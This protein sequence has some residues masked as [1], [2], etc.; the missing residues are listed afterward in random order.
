MWDTLLKKY[1]ND[2]GRVNYVAWKDEQSVLQNW[3]A[4]IATL[5]VDDLAGAEEQLAL[6][7]NLYNAFTVATILEKYPIKSVLPKILGIPNWLSFLSF[8]QRQIYVYGGRNYSLADIENKILREKL[9]EPRIHFAIVCASIGCPN[10]RAGAYYPEKVRG[11]LEDDARR[12]INNPEKVKYDAANNILYC[13]KIFKWYR[14]DFLKVAPSLPEYIRS[15]LNTDLP[16]MPSTPVK[17]LYY[18]WN[19]NGQ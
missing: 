17:Y 11:Q 14:Q 18:D 2:Q 4:N 9:Q 3:L 8:F 6:W 10:L 13:S 19:L 1:V 5:Q 7:I 16:L 12:F 15:Y